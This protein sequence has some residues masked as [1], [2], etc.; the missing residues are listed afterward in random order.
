M[1]RRTADAES[2]RRVRHPGVIVGRCAG[3][4]QRRTG[5][6]LCRAG[7]WRDAGFALL[8]VEPRADERDSLAHE[9]QQ[10]GDGSL[11]R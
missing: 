10:E 8:L 3:L 11:E 4:W 1:V 7:E 6:H 9:I 5:I 2:S